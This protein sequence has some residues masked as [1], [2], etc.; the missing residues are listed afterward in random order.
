MGSSWKCMEI[1]WKNHGNSMEIS[2]IFYGFAWNFYGNF[3]KFLRM[4]MEKLWNVLEFSMDCME[5][6]W[7]FLRIFHRQYGKNMEISKKFL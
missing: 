7:N 4:C 5:F 6:L 2:G 3:W 1:L